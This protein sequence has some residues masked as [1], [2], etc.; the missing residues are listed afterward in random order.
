MKRTLDKAHDRSELLQ[1]TPSVAN[2]EVPDSRYWTTY[3]RYMIE[4]QA[5][6]IRREFVY[7]LITNAWRRLRERL[8]ASSPV[9]ANGPHR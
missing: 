8:I 9:R 6:A 3:D 4:R 2:D 7:A 5:R 1:C